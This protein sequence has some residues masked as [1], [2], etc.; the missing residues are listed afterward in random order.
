MCEFPVVCWRYQF[1]VLWSHG[2][3]GRDSEEEGERLQH[4]PDLTLEE[5]LAH[6]VRDFEINA[7]QWGEI[8]GTHVRPLCYRA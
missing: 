2:C 6:L 7:G 5:S 8:F 4:P 1:Q 3:Q